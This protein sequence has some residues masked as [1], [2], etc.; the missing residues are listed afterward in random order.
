MDDDRNVLRL[1]VSLEDIEH[2]PSVLL[3]LKDDVEQDESW[4]PIATPWTHMGSGLLANK[5]RKLA[6]LSR[7]I[8][9]SRSCGLAHAFYISMR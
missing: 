2:I 8:D 7:S 1:G 4:P 3:A 5:S 9:G 6:S